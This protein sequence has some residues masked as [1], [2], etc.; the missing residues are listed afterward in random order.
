MRVD[1]DNFARS[2]YSRFLQEPTD[3]NPLTEWQTEL[4]GYEYST[5]GPGN[6][7]GVKNYSYG[8]ASHKIHYVDYVSPDIFL[9]HQSKMVGF[10]L[11][12][13]SNDTLKTVDRS[14]KN[15]LLKDSSLL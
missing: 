2:I 3:Y 6:N 14:V 10:Y 9:V 12:M 11:K 1:V 13:S 8:R 4:G 7:E 15:R 5:L